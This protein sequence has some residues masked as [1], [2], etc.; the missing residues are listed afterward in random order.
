MIMIKMV[1]GK[2]E[3]IAKHNRTN[4]L[5]VVQQKD[6]EKRIVHC[7]G[8]VMAFRGTMVRFGEPKSF[9][10][11]EVTV[12]DC[13]VDAKTLALMFEQTRRSDEVRQLIMSGDLEVQAK[14]DGTEGK[15]AKAPKSSQRAENLRCPCH[16]VH[17]RLRRGPKGGNFWA[18]PTRSETHCN[19]TCSLEGHWSD[20]DGQL[21]P[22]ALASLNGHTVAEAA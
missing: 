8:H 22:E 4:E 11:D 14:K 7:H 17:M 16:G 6:L 12:Y 18:C 2:V 10:F 3:R 19:V 20:P 9:R 21:E 15:L 13:L 5:F 1:P